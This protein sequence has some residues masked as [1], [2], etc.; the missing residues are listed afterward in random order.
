MSEEGEQMRCGK[1][2][3]SP[4]IVSVAEGESRSLLMYRLKR[5]AP[6]MELWGTPEEAWHWEER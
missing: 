4:Y 3:S 6:R 1:S 2:M 5:S